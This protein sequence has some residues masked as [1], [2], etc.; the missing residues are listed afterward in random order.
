M[1]ENLVGLLPPL[2]PDA[3]RGW[4]GVDVLPRS[5]PALFES[6]P[7][8]RSE[9][10]NLAP[11]TVDV[12]ATVDSALQFS[13]EP[14]SS[15]AALVDPLLG[16]A[17][18]QASIAA[19][20]VAKVDVSG[21]RTNP[22]LF[23]PYNWIPT[24]NGAQTSNAGAYL[25]F[26]FN[27]TQA[28]LGIDNS[29]LTSFPLLDVY[30]DGVRTQAQL[31]LKNVT[32]GQA[33]IFSG[34][35]GDHDVVVYF[36][37]REVFTT[38]DR[39]VAERKAKDWSNDAEHWRLTGVTVNGGSGFLDNPFRHSKTALFFGDSITEGGPQYYEPNTPDRPTNYPF[40]NVPNNAAFK[41]YAARLGDLLNVD[42]GQVGWSGSGWLR[43][44]TPTGNPPFLDSWLRYNG[45]DST[46]RAFDPSPDYVFVNLGTND[47]AYNI[48][49]TA[50][51][52]LKEARQRLP[53]AEIFLI[54]PFNQ[55][56]TSELSKAITR[57]QNEF[58]Q[59]KQIH[60][61]D[62]GAEGAKG[63]QSKYIPDISLDRL[64]PT[65]RRHKALAGLLWDQ[66]K[67]PLAIT[68]T[69][70]DD[71]QTAS[72][73]DVN[74]VKYSGAWQAVTAPNSLNGDNHRSSSTNDTYEV[75]FYGDR[76]QL[77]GTKAAA[78]G[79]AAISV[80]GG[81]E[82]R[83][84]FYSATTRENSLLYRSGEL[85]HGYHTVRVRVTG[86]SNTSATGNAIALDKLVVS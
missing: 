53:K 22:L 28:T 70:I 46:T 4:D 11:P 47:K 41:T 10:D 34:S 38:T 31:W 63:L 65:G 16:T 21:D 86:Q 18:S 75:T 60:G 52:W 55:I 45:K 6:N 15:K 27:G 49:D 1:S 84:D 23:S 56:K 8:P 62:L 24:S 35:S 26:R 3:N 64:H 9:L 82:S 39:P 5:L 14:K 32:N 33:T 68:N 51:T 40:T 12:S 37:R 61:I 19:A 7:E 50:Y 78:N 76:L 80:D 44:T 71:H 83:T 54:Y 85:G 57:Y 17:D 81:S 58:P 2:L 74:T 69:I 20:Q 66:L 79:I 25:K 48:T 30:V 67:S 36:R 13:T 43:P 72:G 59:D 29:G 42:Y 77:Y 73:T